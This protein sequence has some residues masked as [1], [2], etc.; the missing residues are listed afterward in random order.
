MFAIYVLAFCRIVIGIV[1][2][3]SFVGKIRDLSAFT[4]TIA[5]FNLLPSQLNR[6]V[7][8]IFVGGELAVSGFMIIGGAFLFLGFLLALLLLLIFCIALASVLHR[9]IQTSCNCF[10]AS[11]K[12]ISQYDIVRN[13]G[14]ILCAL[15]GCSTLV[16]SY[17]LFELN[18]WERGL[19]FVLAIVF[20][21]M[22]VQLGEIVQLFK[23]T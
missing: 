1:F 12:Q 5:R 15:G 18:S 23:F 13:I 2:A 6:L 4:N 19:T 11:E 14:F 10:G 16:S 20:V 9:E 7:V 3:W 22:W 21:V 17:G 8:F